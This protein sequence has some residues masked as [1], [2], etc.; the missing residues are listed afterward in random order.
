MVWP[1]FASRESSIS[2][3]PRIQVDHLDGLAMST[4]IILMAGCKSTGA[5]GVWGLEMVNSWWKAGF[6]LAMWLDLF[7]HSSEWMERQATK[8]SREGCT[9][10][11]FP[12]YRSPICW[13]KVRFA[14]SC[15]IPNK[16][17]KKLWPQTMKQKHEKQILLL[18]LS[19]LRSQSSSHGCTSGGSGLGRCW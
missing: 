5:L 9:F 6:P 4:R 13:I 3:T 14:P 10:T 15:S 2:R 17:L 12:H 19:F 7:D 11:V 16:T 8:Q 18:D 1:L